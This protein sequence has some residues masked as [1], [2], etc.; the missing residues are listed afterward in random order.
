MF[1]EG[2]K[3]L[4]KAVVSTG[5]SCITCW[6]CRLAGLGTTTNGLRRGL[7]PA[8]PCF[9]PLPKGRFNP[10]FSTVR[11]QALGLLS[12]FPGGAAWSAAGASRDETP[13]AHCHEQKQVSCGAGFGVVKLFSGC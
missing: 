13:P 4:T 5:P 12:L 6:D 3:L 9:P 1:L 11:S 8:L 10:T 7:Q 2:H